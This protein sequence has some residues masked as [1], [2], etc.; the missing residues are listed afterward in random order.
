MESWRN[1]RKHIGIKAFRE[2]K[3]AP[4]CTE[5]ITINTVY[6]SQ[7]YIP[8]EYNSSADK[9]NKNLPKEENTNFKT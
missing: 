7:S 4:D 5:L 1:S 2:C 3:G 9:N 8:I 6:E